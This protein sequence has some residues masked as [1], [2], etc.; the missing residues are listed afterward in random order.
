M[1]RKLPFSR[2]PAEIDWYFNKRRLENDEDLQKV[3]YDKASHKILLRSMRL[4]EEMWL[5]V[6]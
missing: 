6:A 4:N 1:A 3:K 5:V 2:A